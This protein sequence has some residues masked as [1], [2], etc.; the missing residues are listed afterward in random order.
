MHLLEEAEDNRNSR[1]PASLALRP[2]QEALLLNGQA[3]NPHQGQS[4][5]SSCEYESAKVEQIGACNIEIYGH[6]GSFDPRP[7]AIRKMEETK[8]HPRSRLFSSCKADTRAYQ[9]HKIHANPC[10]N[11]GSKH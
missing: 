11:Q 1:H 3:C 8:D 2:Q 10:N 9:R 4:I 5:S 6:E 7:S